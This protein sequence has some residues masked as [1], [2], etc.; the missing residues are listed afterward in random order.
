[1]RINREGNSGIFCRA[2]FGPRNARA[3]GGTTG[4]EA[5]IYP[6]AGPGRGGNQFTG[7][8][9]ANNRVVAPVSRMLAPP[10][11]WF[12]L[13][14]VVKGY[15]ITTI[16]NGARVVQ[17]TDEKRYHKKGHIALQLQPPATV[18]E[19]RKIEVKLLNDS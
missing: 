2:P 14:L 12:T 7:C 11:T 13:E 18:V 3:D 15:E 5:Q 9:W 19:F 1:M 16:V 10:D 8:V 4:Y 17:Y 6:S